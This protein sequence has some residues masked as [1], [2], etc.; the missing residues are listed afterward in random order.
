MWA[1]FG[2]LALDC[3]LWVR[4][5]SGLI[6][7][8]WVAC[9]ASLSSPAVAW[10]ACSACPHGSQ[11]LLGSGALP[12]SQGVFGSQGL[13]GPQNAVANHVVAM[14]QVVAQNKLTKDDEDTGDEASV[15]LP[16]AKDPQ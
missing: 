14:Q 3:C 5:L 15:E 13:L 11:G 10:V 8:A 2:V 16:L 7:D 12:G 9:F 4:R 1:V 6:G